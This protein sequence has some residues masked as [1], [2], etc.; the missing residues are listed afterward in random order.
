[1]AVIKNSPA[2]IYQPLLAHIPLGGQIGER[3]SLKFMFACDA[4]R[5]SNRHMQSDTARAADTER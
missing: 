1:M 4:S 2:A 5:L 3:V